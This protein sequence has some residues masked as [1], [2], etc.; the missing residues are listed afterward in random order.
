MP[1]RPRPN[2]HEFERARERELLDALGR[3]YREV[4]AAYAG[5]R[6][7]TSTD[8]CRF[9]VTGREPYVTSLELLAVRRAIAARGGVLSDRRKALPLY[10]GEVKDERPC[11]LLDRH[12]KCSIYDARPLGCR[13]FWCE[14]AEFAERAVPRESV[15]SFVRRIQELA[16]GHERDGER[17]RPL[18]RALDD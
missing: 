2:P 5:H 16:A 12:G 8:C 6:C 11:P 7:P 1:P 18:T 13:T 17:G 9:G 4:D 10:P 15:A 3:I 14:R